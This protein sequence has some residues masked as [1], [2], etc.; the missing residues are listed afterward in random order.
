MTDS[1]FI[2]CFVLSQV[3]IDHSLHAC[4][5]QLEAALGGW[6]DT[7]EN[8]AEAFLFSVSPESS[9]SLSQLPG[10]ESGVGEG[11][12]HPSGPLGSGHRFPISQSPCSSPDFGTTSIQERAG[13]RGEAGTWP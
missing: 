5:W 13:G 11:R 7:L 1:L 4:E 6:L 10:R 12:P 2:S 8:K 9:Y 3:Q